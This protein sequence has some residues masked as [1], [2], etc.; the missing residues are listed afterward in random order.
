LE[1][2]TVP[3]TIALVPSE[4]VPQLVGER[5]TWTATVSDGPKAGLV[6]QFSDGPVHG[7]FHVA[8]DFSPDNH[9]TW[10]PMEEGRYRIRVTVKQGYAGTDAVSAVVQDVV[11]TRVTGTDAVITPL[12]NPLV[13]LYSAPPVSEET[14]HGLMHV[15]FSVASAHPSWRSTGEL[16]SEEGKSTNF[17]VAGMLPNTTY[18]MRHVLQDG[19]ASAP[20]LFTTGSL[21]ATLAFPA[22]TVQQPPA[23]GS[24]LNQDMIFHSMFSVDPY[25]NVLKTVATD[26]TGRVVWYFDAQQPGLGLSNILAPGLVPGGT[27]LLLGHDRYSP[28][29][30]VQNVLREIDLAGDPL[31]ETSLATVNAQLTALGHDVIYGFHHDVQRLPNGATAVLGFTERTVSIHGTPTAYIGDMIVVLDRNFQVAWAWDTFDHLDVNRAA[32][33]G[34]IAVPGGP[35]APPGLDH[36]AVDWTHSN[37]LAWSPGDGNLTLSVRHQDWVIKIDYRGGRGDGHIL[38]RF[39]KG[40]DFTTASTDPYPWPSHQHDAHLVDATT[41]VLFDN[42]N[43]RHA[44]DPNAHNRGQ[45]WTLNEETMTATPVVDVDLGVFSMAFGAAQRL[46]NGNFSFTSGFQGR[47]PNLFGQT[48]EVL[49]DGTTTY[50]LKVASGEYRSYRLRTLYKATNDLSDNDKEESERGTRGRHDHVRSSEPEELTILD[51]PPPDDFWAAAATA[52]T[53]SP[54]RSSTPTA[55]SAAIP[56]S[57]EA[58]LPL[59]GMRHDQFFAALTKAGRESPN[60][61][62]M[63]PR[64]V[65][66]LWL[67]D[68]YSDDALGKRPFRARLR[69]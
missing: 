8:R 36:V 10:T 51:R 60:R 61:R 49:P 32:T 14:T 5:I 16:P 66:V 65:P 37:A 31:R 52:L 45:A 11:R 53:T 59:S 58:V 67:A 13:A 69:D 63:H 40:G 44:K 33:L 26:L 29:P 24:D 2:R 28:A 56:P 39:G 7:P 41:L 46:S 21:P 18:E 1:D 6:Y 23:P 9:F 35:G 55:N 4:A 17:L 50:V 22:F 12:S 3:S 38:W 62:G 47:L 48:F 54:E 25:N 42:G 43:A 34:D 30:G 64:D 15:E 68:L 20:L 19:T 57:T 27:V